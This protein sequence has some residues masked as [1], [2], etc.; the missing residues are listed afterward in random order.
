VVRPRHESIHSP[1]AWVVLGVG[2]DSVIINLPS[3]RYTPG[4]ISAVGEVLK[5]LVE[6]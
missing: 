1:P 4:V 6:R 2:I 3:H 5:P